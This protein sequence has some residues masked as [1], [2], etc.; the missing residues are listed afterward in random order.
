MCFASLHMT[1]F[2]S[3]QYLMSNKPSTSGYQANHNADFSL[4][5]QAALNMLRPTIQFEEREYCL[6]QK[7]TAKY[8]HIQKQSFQI[9]KTCSLW[10][11]VSSY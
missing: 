4:Y 8:K 7:C 3:F 2:L 6:Q 11:V 10:D 9:S 5:Q 1:R